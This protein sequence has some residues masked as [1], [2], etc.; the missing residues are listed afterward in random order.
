MQPHTH[1]PALP[2]EGRPD[3]P[4]R[5][6]S[7]E[8]LAC[9][10]CA[11]WR[12]ML[13]ETLLPRFADRVAFISYD[14]PLEKHPWAERAAMASRRFSSWSVAAGLEFR[15]WC[16]IHRAD[17]SLENL[18]ERIAEFAA[19]HDLDEETSIL[20][21]RSDDLRDAVRADH[22]EGLRRGVAKTPT[23]FVGDACFVEI[24]RVEDVADAIEEA[25]QQQP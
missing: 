16:L 7:F 2:V 4:V 3:S 6:E 14:F 13:D 10:D 9:G 18:P 19:A 20:A 8:D 23:V 15:R 17:V 21:L 22:A 24:F 1:F 25:L 12:A 5:V 11:V